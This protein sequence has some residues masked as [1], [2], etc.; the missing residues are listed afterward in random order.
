MGQ[1]TERLNASL[2]K[3]CPAEGPTT[4]VANALSPESAD[5]ASQKQETQSSD[6]SDAY[7]TVADPSDLRREALIELRL[8]K[9]IEAEEGRGGEEPHTWLTANSV[10]GYSIKALLGRGG[11]GEVF[12]ARHNQ[13]QR[14]VA[15]KLLARP[16][17]LT[18][19]FE[20][21]MQL[22]GKLEHPHIVQTYDAA[23]LDQFSYLAMEYIPG[24][25][26][27]QLVARH[28]PLPSEVV[29]EILR[30]A[31]RA[32]AHL[33]D[34]GIVHRD[35]KPANFMLSETGCVKM[36]DL[37][38]A[39]QHIISSHGGA[40][41]T[42]TQHLLG[43]AAY[44]SPEQGF[45]TK[46]VGPASDI[47][48]LGCTVFFLLTGKNPYSGATAV[49]TF[50]MHRDAP[51]PEPGELR[52]DVDPVLNQWLRS[53]MAKRLEDRPT[54][55]ELLE[56]CERHPVIPLDGLAFTSPPSTLFASGC[57]Q[58]TTAV[59]IG[60]ERP[61]LSPLRGRRRAVLLATVAVPLM[62]LAVWLT[63]PLLLPLPYGLAPR[64]S[65]KI[66][67]AASSRGRL[68]SKGSEILH[69]LS[70]EHAELLSERP[71]FEAFLRHLP[72]NVQATDEAL[73]S[74]MQHLERSS[75]ANNRTGLIHWLPAFVPLPTIVEC[76]RASDSPAVRAACIQMLG[77]Y[78]PAG[79]E[80]TAALEVQKTL[81]YPELSQM[82]VDD[83]DPEVHTSLQWLASRWGWTVQWQ[84]YKGYL[85]QKAFALKDGW[86]QPPFAPT[87]I[88]FAGPRDATL[89]NP[90]TEAGG[91]KSLVLDEGS[92]NVHV[93]R[94]FAISSE[95]V[96]KDLLWRIT[97][98]QSNEPQPVDGR[99]PV[100]S[101]QWYDAAL[102]CNELS[103]AE[104]LPPSEFCYETR[105]NGNRLEVREAPD[106]L[107]RQGYR[108][109]TDDEWEIACRADTQT[110]YPHGEESR[111]LEEYANCFNVAE[112]N[113]KLATVAHRKPNAN[114]MFDM[115]G[116][117]SEW[118]NDLLYVENDRS[119]RV[120]GGSVWTPRS[121]VHT[122]AQYWM[123][124]RLVKP[125]ERLGFR[126]AR[127]LRSEPLG[128]PAGLNLYVEVASPNFMAATDSASRGVNPGESAGAIREDRPYY[129]VTTNQP[130]S[131]GEWP[132]NK[133]PKKRFRFVNES[134]ESVEIK[135][136][137]VD[138]S[139]YELV[140][141]PATVIEPSQSIEFEVHW[142]DNFVG[143]RVE[144]LNFELG[145][146]GNSLTLHSLDIHLGLES[147]QLMI[148][149]L[150]EFATGK[151][152]VDLG[153]VPLGSTLGREFQLF[154]AGNLPTNVRVIE[155]GGACKLLRNALQTLV[156]GARDRF[157]VTMAA[158]KLGEISGSLVVHS[159]EGAGRRI[160]IAIRANAVDGGKFRM[161]G[162]FREGRWLFN[163]NAD[164]ESFERLS[165]GEPSGLPLTGDWNGDGH[166]DVG[167]CHQDADGRWHWS[168]MM[169]GA[170]I[171][172]HEKHRDFIW[173]AAQERPIVADVNGD[174]FTDFGLIRKHDL[175]SIEN[176]TTEL[177]VA[178]DTDGDRIADLE[179]KL[180]WEGRAY[181]DIDELVFLAGDI[182]GDGIDELIIT[183]A[184]IA[185]S[186]EIRRWRICY[187][188]GHIQR[189]YF[190]LNSQFPI[191]GDWNGDGCADLGASK[192][193]DRRMIFSFNLDD[194][195]FA[196]SDLRHWPD[197]KGIPV[198][199]AK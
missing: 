38:L 23:S 195:P 183:R 142:K 102:F 161:P 194:D 9:A 155:V 179:R 187:A 11:M 186:M 115:L 4:P 6:S 108:L 51:I 92:R 14:D 109:P 41:Q 131:F 90:S 45:D 176:D 24:C 168:L 137:E 3:A 172:V 78:A 105:R 84:A 2:G 95:E 66:V 74:L 140:P 34:Q 107:E 138:N 125:S 133:S 190:G 33:H 63:S 44:A 40:P 15:L 197:P 8:P 65:S 124:E 119:R 146:P 118:T 181:R 87:M 42:L 162:T 147:S 143:S 173:G 128:L 184:Q 64:L 100:N 132:M 159:S 21:E 116:N 191:V 93:P 111:W 160:E 188:D 157:Y 135:Q 36:L 59:S 17:S 177:V 174:G 193:V 139:L 167:V 68:Q 57:S 82:Y 28:G 19:R 98:H 49:E 62:V 22:S 112:T 96:T 16:S 114:G 29:I 99:T 86:Y 91:E 169:R 12:L 152:V 43:T 7:L 67:P 32:L 120:R 175:P 80:A 110:L 180:K 1:S 199:I 10:P 71:D 97:S 196:E 13:L 104:G 26:L 145:R 5:V 27:A 61:A 166:G 56:Q 69:V 150:G 141:T 148:E 72:K 83:P 25:N 170:E 106:A 149:D 117:I 37:G 89:G 55:A 129:K 54:A 127:T 50:I 165:F 156:P 60:G 53:M 85:Q 94:T 171:P 20:R 122:A 101:I 48:S 31:L 70:G 18:R 77:V 189:V 163:H 73:Q 130:I 164:L 39:K 58:P 134:S 103:K 47:Y 154:N 46:T 178:F 158:E 198:T 30:Q 113:P 75:V 151:F 121:G 81:L 185:D 79:E 136:L 123:S 52:D 192:V 76:M 144:E 153:N 35:I 126:V 88:I 182:D